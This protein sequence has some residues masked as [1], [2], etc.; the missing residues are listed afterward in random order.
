M[1]V[2]R[3]ILMHVFGRPRGILGRLGGMVMA[4]TNEDCGAWVADL[5]QVEPTDSV[6]EIGF[7][8]GVIVRRLSKLA[9]AG[10]V[11]GIDP[12]SE[13]VAQARGRNEISIK[14]GRVEL[15]RCSVESL[16]F[17]DNTFDKALT[18]N[19]MQVWPDAAAGLREMRRVLKPTARVALGFTPHS[20]QPNAG[21]TDILT[22]AGFM[23]A[24]VVERDKWF[25]ALASKP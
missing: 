16:P 5:L 21:L 14:S 9:S 20:G 7:G 1:S 6:L 19:S 13:M 23:E 4:R 8:P 10:H 3:N 12:S 15:L 17:D 25:C 11:T 22:A 18:I 24:K 2:T